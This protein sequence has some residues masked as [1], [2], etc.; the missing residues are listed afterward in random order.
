M[1][2][3]NAVALSEYLL[4]RDQAI[5]E[6]RRTPAPSAFRQQEL[7]TAIAEADRAVKSGITSDADDERAQRAA[8][9]PS[10]FPVEPSNRTFEDARVLG[11]RLGE[12]RDT[13]YAAAALD[14][15]PIPTVLNAA[16]RGSRLLQRVN[17]VPFTKARGYIAQAEPMTAEVI[18]RDGES[19]F[20]KQVVKGHLATVVKIVASASVDKTTLTDMLPAEETLRVSIAAAVGRS[21]DRALVNGATD[22]EN[23]VTGLLTD[24]VSVSTDVAAFNLSAL[25]GAVARITDAGGAADV[26][27]ADS[28][29]VAALSESI[30]GTKLNRLPELVALPPLAD[31]TVTIPAGTVIVADLASAAVAVRQNLEVIKAEL[32]PEAF[33]TDSVFVAGRIRIGGISLPAPG[34]AQILVNS[35]A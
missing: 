6:L 1:T 32:A 19:D 10:W 27:L 11:V 31:G 13:E 21:V 25:L 14:N 35:A 20:T 2:V 33:D 23:T 16:G 29:T 7:L 18:G 28:A 30:D 22:G 4:R 24:G 26:I 5:T 3:T 15:T 17:A 12:M 9:G 8:Q 34:F